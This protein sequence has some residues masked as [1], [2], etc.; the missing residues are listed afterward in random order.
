[1]LEKFLLISVE[2]LNLISI[3]G[4]TYWPVLIAALKTLGGGFILDRLFVR[5]CLKSPSVG[6]K[7]LDPPKSPL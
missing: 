4:L 1:M 6:I 2:L 7:I 3:A 5:G